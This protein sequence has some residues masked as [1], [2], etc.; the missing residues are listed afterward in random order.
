MITTEPTK[1]KGITEEEFFVLLGEPTT[2]KAEPTAIEKP[3]EKEEIIDGWASIRGMNNSTQIIAEL[4]SVGIHSVG[5]FTYFNLQASND[6]SDISERLATLKK[7]IGSIDTLISK[8]KQRAVLSVTYKEYQGLS[9]LKQKRFKKK[10]T[11]AI[12]SYEQADK[13][14][15][16]HIKAYKVGGKAPTVAEMKKYSSTLKDEYNSNLRGL[17]TLEKKHSVTSRYSR[18]VRNYINQQTNKR[19][20][21][22]SRQRCLSQQ[23][24]KDTLE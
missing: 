4:E 17:Q 5:E 1:S 3:P 22:Q 24:K 18:S 19:A 16:E 13:Y 15:K 9:G 12:D 14:I 21:E 10:N 23:K 2:P 20:T 6:I 11:D 7:Q 8:I